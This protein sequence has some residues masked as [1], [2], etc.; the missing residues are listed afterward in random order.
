MARVR[1]STGW[2]RR[3]GATHDLSSHRESGHHSHRH[4]RRT[5]RRFSRPCAGRTATSQIAL[6][7]AVSGVTRTLKTLGW[8]YP[9]KL[10]FSPDGRY[11][12][13]NFA[14]D[15]TSTKRDIAVLAADGAAETPIAEHHGNDRVLGWSPDGRLFFSSDRDGSSGR[16]GGQRHEWPCVRGSRAAQGRSLATRARARF[17]PAG[18]LLLLGEPHRG[19]LVRRGHRS[20]FI[21]G[22]DPAATSGR[23]RWRHPRTGRVVARWPIA[24]LSRQRRGG[25]GPFQPSDHSLA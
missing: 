2:H 20:H 12:A 11:I 9:S 3:I 15:D 21:E 17:R 14:R 16:V 22:H 24:R 10:A 23:R 18:R 4:G 8:Q 5:A 13:Y 7:N 19:R 6:I 1:A 25:V